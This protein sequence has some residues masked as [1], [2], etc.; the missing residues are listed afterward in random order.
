MEYAVLEIEGS[1]FNI[2]FMRMEVHQEVD[3]VGRPSSPVQDAH[4]YL[5]LEWVAEDDLFVKWAVEAGEQHSCRI[6]QYGTRGEI[7]SIQA[8]KAWC[9]DYREKFADSA[10]STP[11]SRRTQVQNYITCLTLTAETLSVNEARLSNA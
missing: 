2:L 8:E 1:S 7:K 3:E 11:A 5:E 10:R 9:I 4:L 6:R